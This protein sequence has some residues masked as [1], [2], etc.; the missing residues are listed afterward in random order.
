MATSYLATLAGLPVTAKS[1][2]KDPGGFGELDERLARG[3]SQAP[4]AEL[5][6]VVVA[7]ASSADV[8]RAVGAHAARRL[9]ALGFQAIFA[10]SQAG[11]PLWQE[12]AA[13]LGLAGNLTSEARACAE[14]IV[15]GSK[16]R[17]TAIVAPLPL[18]GTWDRAVAVELCRLA[19][20]GSATPL[21]VFTTSSRDDTLDLDAAGVA[22][23]DVYEIVSTLVASDKKRWFAATA[24]ES[25]AVLPCD[26]LAT[27]EDWWTATQSA[28]PE[29]DQRREPIPDD[30][31]YLFTA[32][33]L[34][35]RA[36]PAADIV[37]LKSG[38]AAVS[39]LLRVAAIQTDRGFL[40][41]LPAWDD[42]AGD[43]AARASAE[44]CNDVAH[45][46]LR[47]YPEDPWARARAGELLLRA[48]QCD[49]GDEAHAQAL[50][51]THDPLARREIVSRWRTA[52][53]A[54]DV[55]LQL[56]LRVRAGER[57]LAAGEADEAYRWAQ[58]ATTLAPASA[59]VMLLLGQSA[60]ATGDLVTAKVALERAR[61]VL[62]AGGNAPDTSETS[63]L[64]AVELSEVGYLTGLLE[65][66]SQEANVAL[67]SGT[68]PSTLLRARNILGKILLAQAK[69]D[70]ADRHFAEDA[71][72]ASSSGEVSAELRARLNRGIA[73]LSKGLLDEARSIFDD[74]LKEGERIGE[75]HACAFAFENLA[76]VA[77]WR[78]EYGSALNLFERALK[79]RQRL[80]DRLRTALILAN[81]S[82]LRFKLGLFE[83][84]DHAISFG[85][86]TIGPGMPHHTSARF[87]I[88]AARLALYRGNTV[89][90]RREVTRAI[91]DGETSAHRNKVASEAYRVATRVALEDGDLARAN[92]A[93]NRA[94]SFASTE[95]ARAEV[96]YLTAVHARAAGELDVRGAIEALALSRSV[97]EEELLREAHVLLFE[98]YRSLAAPGSNVELA[99]AHLDQAIALRDQVA[100]VLSGEVR[101]A[102]LARRDVSV[103]TR[104][105]GTLC[106]T[107][108]DAGPDACDE[109]GVSR[110]LPV[111][112][113]QRPSLYPASTSRELI[114]DDPA[115]RGLLSAIRKVAR[116]DSTVLIRGESGTGK[117][118]V[119]EALHRASERA[120]GPL[121]TVNCAALVETLL[122]SE[123][124]GHEKGAFTGAAARRR[125]RFELAEGGTLFLD[126]IGDISPRTQ[127]ALLR[128]L[129]ERTFERVGGTTA[130]RANV[131]I[132]CAT[133]RDLRGM[134]ER[135]DFREDLYY[136]LRGI[137]LEVP[138]LRAR[139][140]D[141]PRISE[142]LLTRIAQERGEDAKSLS[143]GALELLGRH[144]WPGNVRELENALRAA[145]LF[146]ESPV[147][148]VSDLT[149]NVDDLRI[150]SRPSFIPPAP[151]SELGES[152][153]SN[154][155]AVESAEAPSSGAADSADELPFADFGGALPAGEAGATAV[156]YACVRQGAVSLSDLKRQIER[157]CIARAL[158]ETK[159]NI[160]RAAA[161]L[162]MKRP[163]LS[164]LVKQYGLAAVSEVS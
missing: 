86:R 75:A 123:L 122:L 18:A 57:A 140:G 21:L 144:R 65:D 119:A 12:A 136:R 53:D 54:L 147:I 2:A 156:A 145:A 55:S 152:E 25:H 4:M 135:G 126:E 98:I 6:G 97:G 23:C 92:E 66:A 113:E 79:L 80:G 155:V 132:V 64:I 63:A 116:A 68:L 52:V 94:K 130:I 60:V 15:A 114:G 49:A 110:T 27:L 112:R 148:S 108:P 76:V 37:S 161:L 61:T 33:A 7:R 115:I 106:G 69:W 160:T 90:A 71:W 41:M 154:D 125:G 48:A 29:R 124:F 9:A 120:A 139:M 78:H 56:P 8:A 95:A 159:G 82:E 16:A 13:K 47:S 67:R 59:A 100:A 111:S 143:A 32:L 45:A 62:A 28:P 1:P 74:V 129:Q 105:P 14:Q 131:R 3:P 5:G 162:G 72:T 43:A 81:L 103:L 39:A 83:H 91:V 146:A 137:T 24:E 141:L 50:T 121:V 11:A 150:A 104:L 117:E 85:R 153:P 128:V 163:R 20:S 134:V 158:A 102:F 142:N 149:D 70:E 118:L 17:P 34:A 107:T 89:E 101:E 40:A 157:D 31:E 87:S 164:Q 10:R 42:R 151:S 19:A 26:D 77:M 109:E 38:K 93:L 73:L 44:T 96:A 22:P 127:V 51:R 46:L 30:G 35:Q 88:V 133:H 99:R 138:A 58:S 36:W 84:A